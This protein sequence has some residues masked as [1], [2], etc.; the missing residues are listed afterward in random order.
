MVEFQN[1]VEVSLKDLPYIRAVPKQLVVLCNI[2]VNFDNI[3]ICLEQELECINF[4]G[5][6]LVVTSQQKFLSHYPQEYRFLT[7]KTS[8][9]GPFV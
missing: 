3:L 8:S 5:S 2:V 1:V 9:T 6:N 7:I 4:S